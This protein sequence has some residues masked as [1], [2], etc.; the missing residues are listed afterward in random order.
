MNGSANWDLLV[1]L[2]VFTAFM[3]AIG[4]YMHTHSL[5]EPAREESATSTRYMVENGREDDG[6]FWAAVPALPGV[7]AYGV[8]EDEVKAMVSAMALRALAERLESKQVRAHTF[9]FCLPPAVKLR[10]RATTDH[11]II[12]QPFLQDVESMAADTFE[13]R[14][15]AAQWLQRPHS[16]LNNMAPLHVAQTEAGAERVKAILVSIKY[17]GV[18]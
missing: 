7:Q 15:D 12:D 4:W 11:G 8:N 3:C 18:A 5:P 13:T 10:S 2:G 1:V 14:E 9:V 17:G 16:M 6:R